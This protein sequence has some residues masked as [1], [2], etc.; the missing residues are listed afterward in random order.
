LKVLTAIA[1]KFNY[2]IDVNTLEAF[3]PTAAQEESMR[4]LCEMMGYDMKYYQSAITEI[5]MNFIGDK[6]IFTTNGITDLTLPMFS[7][8]TNA[9]KD[10]NYV[11]L[12]S[13]NFSPDLTS[14]NILCIEGQH[15]L[16]STINN[17]IVTIDLL[18]DNNRFYL[19]ETQI[20]EN[21]IFVYSIK[22]GVKSTR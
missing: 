12:E 9:E 20:A 16:C 2:N 7:S 17:N 8:I 19:P 13:K 18:D 6:S 15:V 1:D 21:G 11:T 4:N 3:M 5:A 10:I 14:Q 22:D